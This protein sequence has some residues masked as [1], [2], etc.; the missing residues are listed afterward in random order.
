VPT[1]RRLPITL[2]HRVTL[3]PSLPPE[4]VTALGG[5]ASPHEARGRTS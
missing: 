5:L 4:E 2:A 3:D 1:I